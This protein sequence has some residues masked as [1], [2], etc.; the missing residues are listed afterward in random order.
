MRSR[1]RESSDAE[2]VR[3]FPLRLLQAIRPG[4]TKASLAKEIQVFCATWP[5]LEE[6]G[7]ASDAL[8]SAIFA[9]SDPTP[10]PFSEQAW[11][12]FLFESY[13]ANLKWGDDSYSSGVREGE[14]ND[15]AML[16]WSFALSRGIPDEGLISTELCLEGIAHYGVA[17]KNEDML[18]LLHEQSSAILLASPEPYV[19]ECIC[20][21]CTLGEYSGRGSRAEECL[22]ARLASRWPADP[23]GWCSRLEMWNRETL[24]SWLLFDLNWRVAVVSDAECARIDQAVS[25]ALD[26]LI[27]RLKEGAEPRQ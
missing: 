1:S 7:K 22:E 12:H 13:F 10:S 26:W 19:P 8:A 23:N 18:L 3:S 14:N 27:A 25:K 2:D 21:H 4:A 9:A 24:K 6:M 17:C 16:L 11:R 20:C 15:I 5:E